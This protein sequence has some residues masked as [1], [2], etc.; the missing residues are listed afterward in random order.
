MVY[1]TNLFNIFSYEIFN[2]LLQRFCLNTFVEHDMA[3]KSDTNE[4]DQRTALPP[5]VKSNPR[6]KI[7]ENNISVKDII[8]ARKEKNPANE[9][10]IQFPSGKPSSPIP[11]HPL[12][13][14]WSPNKLYFEIDEKEVIRQLWVWN[15]CPR[16]IYLHCCGLWDETAR[17]GASWK[18]YPRTRFRLAPGLKGELFVRAI[19]RNQSP[20][21]YSFFGLQVAAAHMRDCVTGHFIVPVHVKFLKYV[22]PY[23]GEGE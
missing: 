23:L 10:W 22:S 17:L 15:S 14:A 8:L 20:V 1:F 18:C 3:S 2:I 7:D 21:P 6:E 9:P 16:T 12:T 13:I 11:L 19:P 4:S 5:I